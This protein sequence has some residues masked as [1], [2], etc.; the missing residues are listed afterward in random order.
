MN[1]G[2]SAMSTCSGARLPYQCC[3]SFLPIHKFPSKCLA[4]CF[5]KESGTAL[6]LS[7]FIKWQWLQPIKLVVPY[8]KDILIADLKTTPDHSGD[9]GTNVIELRAMS[10]RTNYY[11]CGSWNR[12]CLSSSTIIYVV[13]CS[14]DLTSIISLSVS[15]DW[16]CWQICHSKP[17]NT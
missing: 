6:W 13:D 14:I 16:S 17:C 3:Y 10:N 2:L 9:N 15:L 4:S 12:P 7:F 5:W 11:G 1:P 8:E